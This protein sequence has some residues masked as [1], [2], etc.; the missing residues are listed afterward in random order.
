MKF[1]GGFS[2]YFFYIIGKKKLSEDFHVCDYYHIKQGPSQM[3]WKYTAIKYVD[4][5]FLICIPLW[6]F[7]A[8]QFMQHYKCPF[9][10]KWKSEWHDYCDEIVKNQ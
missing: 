3:L 9:T 10:Q 4:E 7:H 8:N 5:E 6:S 1:V 2:H